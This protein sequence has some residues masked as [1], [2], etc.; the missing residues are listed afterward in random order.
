M[1]V[2]QLFKILSAFI[3]ILITT[4]IIDYVFGI[5]SKKTLIRNKSKQEY[6]LSTKDNYDII[7][8]G[9]SRAN[10]HYDTPFI[11]DSLGI[12]AFNA[13]EDGRGLTYQVPLIESYINNNSPKVIVLEV[14]P[15]LNGAWNDR[16]SMLYPL[17]SRYPKITEVSEWVDPYNRYFL[18]SNLFRHNSNLMPEFKT[19]LHP[20][21]PIEKRGFEPLPQRAAIKPLEY[22]TTNSDPFSADSIEEKALRHILDLCQSKNIPIVGVMSPVYSNSA[23]AHNTASIFEEYNFDFLDNSKFRLPISAEEYFQDPSHLNNVGAREYTKF[24]MKQLSDSLHY[25]DLSIFNKSQ[26]S[27]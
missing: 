12:N 9:S 27:L 10:H 21:K 3:V 8:F 5:I 6:V 19:V 24:F 4:M 18:K 17:A 23:S 20:F 7:F 14:F 25:L 1:V 15:I 22:I 16:I 13:G 11:T 26:S 2:K